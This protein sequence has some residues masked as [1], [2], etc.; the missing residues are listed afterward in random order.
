MKRRI[1]RDSRGRIIGID[2]LRKISSLKIGKKTYT[3]RKFIKQ[4]VLK[5][6][7]ERKPKKL[8]TPKQKTPKK[9]TV[10]ELVVNLPFKEKTY[11]T[12][13]GKL[14][15]FYNT[16]FTKSVEW[17]VINTKKKFVDYYLK[18]FDEVSIPEK[19]VRLKFGITVYDAA[20]DR[21]A[22]F[23]TN[24]LD[25]IE[26]NFRK[27]FIAP[28]QEMFEKIKDLSERYE[29]ALRVAEIQTRTAGV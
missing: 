7:Q 14:G 6:R 12:Q 5:L 3:S 18:F 26:R 2:D 9:K 17:I 28:L 24:Y 19:S 20:Q 8:K 23:Y 13:L 10:K 21:G 16:S 4:I 15:A 1:F 25:L 29:I 22:S 27:N 11:Q